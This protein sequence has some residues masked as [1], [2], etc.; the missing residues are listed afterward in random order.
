MYGSKRSKLTEVYHGYC[1]NFNSVTWTR[2]LVLRFVVL[3]NNEH[4]KL[5]ITGPFVWGI[6]WRPVYSLHKGPVMSKT[7]RYHDVIMLNTL[8][9][10]KYGRHFADDIYKC[11]SL[12]ENGWIQ[13]NISLKFVPNGPINNIP[14]LVQVMAWRRPG[15]KPLSEPVMVRLPT[16]ICVTRPQWVKIQFR[17]SLGYT[18]VLHGNIP[19]KLTTIFGVYYS[20]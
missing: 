4:I 17:M 19:S 11:I 7:F 14:A 18:I 13:N 20:P 16:H 2:L 12:N 9:P 8:R 1:M 15:D 10:R 6:Q 5:C 3:N